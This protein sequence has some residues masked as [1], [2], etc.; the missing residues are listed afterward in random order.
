MDSLT[1]NGDVEQCLALS[2]TKGT[3]DENVRYVSVPCTTFNVAVCEVR[4]QE[5]TTYGWL[6]S[7]WVL[8]AI[9]SVIILTIIITLGYCIVV[10]CCPRSRIEDRNQVEENRKIPYPAEDLPT[11]ADVVTV[12]S[13]TE[14][15]TQRQTRRKG[16]L[17]W[18][19][20]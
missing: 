1:G 4:V 13:E 18:I 8:L 19:P 12:D 14:R 20:L 3:Q 7:N 6:V 5:V 9:C 11:Y 15:G 10:T 16:F 17:A 2:V